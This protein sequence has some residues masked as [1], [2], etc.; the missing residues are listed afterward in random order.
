L[1]GSAVTG[2][3]ATEHVFSLDQS[4]QRAFQNNQQILAAFEDIRVA[5]QRVIE[6]KSQ[7]YPKVGLNFNV[8]RYR[9][10]DDF[11]TPPDFGST[12]LRA[13]TVSPEEAMFT[14]TRLWMRQPL[15]AAGRMNNTVRLAQANQERARIRYEEVRNQVLYQTTRAFYDLLLERKRIR[16]YEELNRKVQDVGASLPATS[17]ALMDVRK[18]QRDLRRELADLKRREEKAALTYLSIIGLELYTKIDIVGELKTAPLPLELQKLLAWA[19]EHRLELRRTEYQQEID[20]VAVSLSMSERYPTV[21]FGAGYQV[22]EPDDRVFP[23]SE[24]T[25][26]WVATLNV[27]LPIFDGFS[28][29]AR[30]RQSRIQANQNQ[31]FK[32][33]IED[34]INRE[35]REAFVD[36]QFWQSEMA[37]REQEL[38]NL[39]A[40]ISS[41]ASGKNV[42]D[43]IRAEESILE[44]RLSYWEAV[45]GHILAVAR[46][47]K[48]VGKTLTTL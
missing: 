22:D 37:I 6:A 27:S 15:Y 44:A 7:Y 33:E 28:S 8:S 2:E 39:E 13:N 14:T 25:S 48:A 46:L 26:N 18:K 42:M 40:S 24:K 21:S 36:F 35:V 1:S 45:H 10:E 34:Q 19:N 31:I 32:A 4:V 47:E 43:R 23:R 41:G 30:I 16:F 20:K 29:R 38:K 17:E 11:V 9:A 12:F 3:T 5:E